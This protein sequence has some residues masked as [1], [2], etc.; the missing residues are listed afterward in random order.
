LLLVHLGLLAAHEALD[1]ED[2]V[3]G[4]GDRLA[5]RDGA[6]QALAALREGD[7]RRGGAPTLAVLDHRRLAA[8]QDGHARVRGAEVDTDGLCHVL[9]SSKCGGPGGGSPP[10][11]ICGPWGGSPSVKISVYLAQII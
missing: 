5:L 2:G 11:K 4:I 8:L 10:V 7:H 1:G 9:S 6:D 3:G